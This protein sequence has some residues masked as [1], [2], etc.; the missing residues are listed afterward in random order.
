MG[1]AGPGGRRGAGFGVS[2]GVQQ[3]GGGAGLINQKNRSMQNNW[4]EQQ[5]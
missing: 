4:R 3:R 2:I 1:L 5:G